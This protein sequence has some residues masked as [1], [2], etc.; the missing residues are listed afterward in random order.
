VLIRPGAIDASASD[1]LG[2]TEQAS[3]SQWPYYRTPTAGLDV[4][5]L[6][7]TAS[8]VLVKPAQDTLTPTDAATVSVVRNLAAMDT[9]ALGEAVAFVLESRANLF[10]YHPFIG[11]GVPGAPTAPP[12]SVAYDPSSVAPVNTFFYPP[13]ATITDSVTLRSPELGNKDRLQFNRI[14]RETRGGTLVVYA[15]PIW[16]KVQVQVL[17][18]TGLVESQARGLLDF[19]AAHLGEEVGWIDWEQRRWRG[20]ITNPT[21]AVVQDGREMYTANVE[22]E[23]TLA[24]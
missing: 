15:D 1:T 16:P 20:I 7:E 9:L 5:T 12:A 19:L 23:G 21:D 2:L 4:L 13:D 18:F 24:T 3:V 11:T 17:T 22:L 8:A 10:Q 6:S 14:S